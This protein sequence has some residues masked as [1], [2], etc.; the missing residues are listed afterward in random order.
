MSE[1][2]RM[3]WVQVPCSFGCEAR[4]IK[5]KRQ[6]FEAHMSLL[7][8]M[9]FAC[10]QL[11][12]MQDEKKISFSLSVSS[13]KCNSGNQDSGRDVTEKIGMRA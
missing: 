9:V 13:S 5:I 11:R 12:E 3:W 8:R 10:S 2:F 1:T 7:Q 4:K 6:D